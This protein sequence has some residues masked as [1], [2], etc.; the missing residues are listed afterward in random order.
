MFNLFN[1]SLKWLSVGSAF[2][3]N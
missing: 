2:S 3:I 1:A